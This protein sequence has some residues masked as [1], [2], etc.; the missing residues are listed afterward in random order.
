MQHRVAILLI[1]LVLCLSPRFHNDAKWDQTP[2]SK[3]S[4]FDKKLDKGPVYNPLREKPFMK[5]MYKT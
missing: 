2:V 4:I 1:L 5:R 3:E